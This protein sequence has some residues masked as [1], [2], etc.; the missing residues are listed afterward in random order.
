[1]EDEHATCE[2]DALAARTHLAVVGFESWAS[3]QRSGA[4]LRSD[5]QL[6]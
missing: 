3:S 5:R 2:R 4:C 6:R 1:M